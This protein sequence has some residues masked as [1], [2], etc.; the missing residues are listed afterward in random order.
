[1][2][3]KLERGKG[4]AMTESGGGGGGGVTAGAGEDEDV[5][6]GTQGGDLV[7]KRLDAVVV[8][9][10][11][12]EPYGAEMSSLFIATAHIGEFLAS[13]KRPPR[14]RSSIHL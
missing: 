2:A 12:G 4:R 1:M 14:A 5:A 3:R 13:G 11:G 9:A 7:G 6:G 8:F 10:C